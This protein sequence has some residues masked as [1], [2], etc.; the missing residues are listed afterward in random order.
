LLAYNGALY[1]TTS[2]GGANGDG[3]I[4]KVTT[5]G[6]ETVLYSFKGGT[7]GTRPEGG[8]TELNGKLY[9]T[10]YEGGDS[11]CE[12][13]GHGC[14]TVFEVSTTGKERVLHAFTGGYTKNADGNFPGYGAMQVLNGTLYGTTELGGEWGHGTVFGIT[15]CGKEAVTYSFGY[16]R[17][18]RMGPDG[19]FPL[20]GLA[21]VRGALFGMTEDGG[22]LRYGRGGS[23]KGFGCGTI[24]KLL[25]SGREAS[26]HHFKG[27]PQGANPVATL[28]SVGDTLYGTTRDGGTD[29]SGT[30]FAAATSIER[31]LTLHSFQGAPS[32][33]SVPSGVLVSSN[34]VLYGTTEGGGNS[35][36]TCGTIFALTTSGTE[37]ILHDFGS[38][39]GD[40]SDPVGG[41][42]ELDGVLYG[43]TTSGGANGD[44]TVFALKI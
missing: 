28:L 14:G 22:G 25:T 32:D 26:L 6:E 1:G 7:D 13:S 20:F 16:E 33:G 18:H 40:G 10:T 39:S 2:G 21:A 8:L 43:T 41:L 12:F 19:A 5:S 36:C 38:A 9:G 31:A 30:V 3:T 35:E 29:G 42:V 17:E 44:G 27:S 11:S 34:G 15:P 23:C 37:S 24:F 4:F